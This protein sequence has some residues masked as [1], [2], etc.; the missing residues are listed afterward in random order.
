MSRLPKLYQIG[1]KFPK[2]VLISLLLFTI[3]S[4]SGSSRLKVESDLT[5]LLPKG[6]ESVQSLNKLKDYFGGASYLFLTVESQNTKQA[7]EFADDLAARVEKH[8][9][10]LYVDYRRPVDYFKKRLWLYVDLP[11]LH[12]VEHRIDRAL[13][14][15]KKNVSSTFSGLADF[16]DPEDRPDLT[17]EDIFQKYEKRAGTNLKELSTDSEGNFLILRV[18]PKENSEDIESSRRFIAE[19]HQLEKELKKEKNYSEVTVGYTGNYETKI[20]VVDQITS[21]IALVSTVVMGL[22]FV[23]VFIY[24]RSLSATL[25][26][27][28]PLLVSLLWTGEF[29]YLFL[30]HLNIVTGFG[31]AVL[32]GLGS[33]YGIYLLS[34][35]YQERKLGTDFKT[36]CDHAFSHTGLATWGSML[37]TVGSFLALLFSKFGVFAEFGIVG[38]LGVLSTYSAMML[39]I[40]AILTLAEK[41]KGRV[42]LPSMRWASLPRMNLQIN[43]PLSH[44]FQILFAP[45]KAGL[46]LLIVLFLCGLAAFSLPSKTKIYFD[47]GQI[48]SS[49]LPGNRLYERVSK[50]V[51]ATLNPTLLIVTGA[52]EEE[53]TVSEFSNRLKEK[54]ADQVV[55]NDVFGLSSFVPKNQTEKK[56]ILLRIEQKTKKLKLF[57][58]D[59]KK[60]LLATLRDS[61]EV[62]PITRK[63]I[64]EEVRRLFVSSVRPDVFAVYLFPGIDRTLSG[65]MERYRREIQEMKQEWSLHFDVADGDFVVS[66]TVNLIQREAPRGLM[67]ILAFLGLVLLAIIRP[68]SRA[69][70]IWIHLV[71]GLILFSGVLWLCQIRLN[72]LNIS[73]I[74]IILGTGIDAFLHFSQRFDECGEM[75]GTLKSKV[76]AIFVASLTSIVGLGGFILTSGSGIRSIGWVS[77][78]GLLVM[79]VLVIFVFPRFLVLK[80]G[81]GRSLS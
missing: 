47:G 2:S 5:A 65:N 49:H 32:G 79:T 67:L 76:P 70:L 6:T 40:P 31:A 36:A 73:V 53:K 38:A 60:T 77:V 21:E 34:R 51:N 25:L 46:G 23:I 55:Y 54:G 52:E 9:S 56:E 11:D 71:G 26:V 28:I 33:D 57:L 3:F 75:M 81:K 20:E 17:F 45:R 41:Y 74:S 50:I 10:V 16:A 13:E 42:R 64:P 62:G 68:L 19:I 29:V 44:W 80:L 18:K 4:F 48:D 78:L 24:F 39:M 22:L 72:I 8:P 12:E 61:I 63:E 14:L 59:G 35:Y 1:M 58:K 27:G 37:T 43:L 7:E 15:E 66:D 69:F 30:G